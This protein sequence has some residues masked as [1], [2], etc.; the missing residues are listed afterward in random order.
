MNYN[1]PKPHELFT[2]YSLN[3]EEQLLGQELNEL[4]RAYLHN[5][6]AEKAELLLRLPFTPEDVIGYTQQEAYLT[7]QVEL[8]DSLLLPLDATESTYKE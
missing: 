3:E 5:L 2:T 7:G 8:L 1:P 6:R 4:Q